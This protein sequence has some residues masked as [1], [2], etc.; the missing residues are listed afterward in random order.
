MWAWIDIRFPQNY[1]IQANYTRYY[2]FLIKNLHMY[3]YIHTYIYIYNNKIVNY[4]WRH[5]NILN[6]LEFLRFPGGMGN[7]C[8]RLLGF[9]GLLAKLPL[10]VL[11]WP[12]LSH[13][14][15]PIHGEIKWWQQMEMG[16]KSDSALSEIRAPQNVMAPLTPVTVAIG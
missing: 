10:T 4:V 9:Q 6:H 11:T 15:Q 12:C 16:N 2:L 7:T 1:N 14:K 3:I 8:H 5:S 13:C